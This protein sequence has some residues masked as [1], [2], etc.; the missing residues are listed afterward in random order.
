M[1]QFPEA[2]PHGPIEEVFPNVFFVTGTMKTELMNAHWHFS[3]NM[4]IVREG[5]SLTLI[6]TV[7]LT[8][9]GLA[10]LDALGRV[11]NIVK[12]GSLHGRDDAFYKA[13]YGA[14]FWA[15]PGMQHEHGLVADK[16]L[17]PGGEMPFAGCSVFD[18]RTIKLPECIL[19]IDREG[20][21]LVACDALQNWETPDEF[22]SDES[23]S[24]MTGMGFFQRG[25]FGPVW[26]QVN[27]PAADDFTR[28]KEL[29]FRHALC[30]HG[31][32]L[33]DIAK[34]AYTERA[35]TVFGV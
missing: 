31:Q 21:I 35:N 7:R 5:D 33:R 16:E 17:V 4:T 11:T 8:D 12:I 20:G 19:H 26:M 30:G 9:E 13:R 28:L 3:R 22:F 10:A 29:S 27:E 32:P 2:L 15:M 18:F 23:R 6:N 14:T 24:M 1:D 34:D 25:N